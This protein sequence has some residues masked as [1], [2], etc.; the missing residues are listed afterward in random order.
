M[1]VPAFEGLPLTGVLPASFILFGV[2]VVFFQAGVVFFFMPVWGGNVR[3]CEGDV[4]SYNKCCH[5][6]LRGAAGR[7]CGP[8]LDDKALTKVSPGACVGKSQQPTPR[9]DSED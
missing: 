6:S 7:R 5:S 1:I 2:A 8:F 3:L 4:R 9:L